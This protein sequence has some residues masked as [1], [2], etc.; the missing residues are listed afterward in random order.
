MFEA[1]RDK[2]ETVQRNLCFGNQ[3]PY[4]QAQFSMK[5]MCQK[6]SKYIVYA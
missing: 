4:I 6:Y 5:K 2:K 1:N 3:I